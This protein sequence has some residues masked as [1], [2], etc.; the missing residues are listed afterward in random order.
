MIMREPRH[1]LRLRKRVVCR[2]VVRAA[3]LPEL[4]TK[5]HTDLKDHHPEA[6]AQ[7]FLVGTRPSPLALLPRT[8]AIWEL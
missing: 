1:V 5:T 8:T 7:P 3:Q 4:L 2:E 6:A